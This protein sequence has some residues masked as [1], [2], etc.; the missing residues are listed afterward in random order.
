MK[1]KNNIDQNSICIP[2]D[3]MV[4]YLKGELSGKEMNTV[5]RHLS[6]CE[7]CADTVEGL[8]MLKDPNEIVSI[9]NRL[10]RRIDSEISKKKIISMLAS[11][12]SIA[13]SFL[14]V[15]S[16]VGLIYY[17]STLTSQT[18]TLSENIIPKEEEADFDTAELAPSTAQEEAIIEKEE[19]QPVK[20]DVANPKREMEIVTLELNETFDVDSFSPLN[21]GKGTTADQ[22]AGAPSPPQ[23]RAKS[24]AS[25]KKIL[26]IVDDDIEISESIAIDFKEKSKKADLDIAFDLEEV[27][28]EEEEVFTIVEEM[29]TF[30]SNDYKD[31]RDYIVK[32]L[33]YPTEA[34][35]NGL[36][37]K[38]YVSFV[39]E[40]D[41]SVSNVRVTKGIDESLDQEAIRVVESSPKWQ[42]GTQRG[43][44][45]RVAYAFPVVFSLE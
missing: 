25:E 34:V 6:G 44:P 43:K 13:A 5:E 24:G 27:E 2:Q 8:G 36:Q 35:E 4:K 20:E 28:V 12:I 18:N 21:E 17:T 7:I 19:P 39:V 11:P 1:S 41:G 3:V 42:P 26:T 32:N 14:I 29:P 31:F 16:I 23:A 45:V 9:T 30:K 37:G 15:L 22:P 38:V 10:N 33:K 40:P